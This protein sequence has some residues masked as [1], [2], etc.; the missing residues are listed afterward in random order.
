[1]SH[2]SAPSPASH[3]GE[4]GQG[5]AGNTIWMRIALP[6]CTMPLFFRLVDIKPR[7][8]Q[9]LMAPIYPRLAPVE[10]ATRLCP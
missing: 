6:G 3:R 1:M 2:R 7:H 9:I 4:Q 5:E 10:V 8:V